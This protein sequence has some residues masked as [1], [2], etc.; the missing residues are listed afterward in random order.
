[1]RHK[2]IAQR[3]NDL[4]ESE[5]AKALANLIDWATRLGWVIALL[6]AIIGFFL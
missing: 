1:M 2:G 3:I 4:C 5:R 6:A